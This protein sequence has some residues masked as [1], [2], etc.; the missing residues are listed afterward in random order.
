MTTAFGI[1]ESL[2]APMSYTA[3]IGEILLGLCVIF[4]SRRVWPQVI[5]AVAMAVLLV[6]VAIYAPR[7]LFGA[8]NPVVMNVA[9]V[10]LSVVAVLAL[11]AEA[12]YADEQ[13][14]AT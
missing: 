12:S 4:L 11:R 7:Y 9:S 3:G 2:Q 14:R 10:A 13:T 1:P 8:F 5:S 6:F